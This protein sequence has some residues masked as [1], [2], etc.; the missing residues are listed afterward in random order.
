MSTFEQLVTIV[1]RKLAEHCWPG[2][3][4]VGKRL[5]LGMQDARIP[6]LTVVGEVADVKEASRDELASCA[7]S[8]R[9]Q[10]RWLSPAA[11]SDC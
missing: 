7:S 4:P 8:L 3:D 2:A 1:G 10:R 5:R 9:P 11:R 6:W